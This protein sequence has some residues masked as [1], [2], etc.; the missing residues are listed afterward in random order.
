M[1]HLGWLYS[2][3][4][5]LDISTALMRPRRPKQYCLQLGSIERVLITLVFVFFLPFFLI[6]QLSL[7]RLPRVCVLVFNVLVC[8]RFFI[9]VSMGNILL[10]GGV[11]IGSYYCYCAHVLRI[12]R[13]SDFLSPMLTNTGILLRGLKLSGESIS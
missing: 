12:S 3:T 2:L 4:S 9:L 6:R 11:A 8:K 7:R 10:T 5:I 13:Y 1:G